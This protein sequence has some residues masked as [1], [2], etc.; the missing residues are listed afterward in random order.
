MKSGGRGFRTVIRYH[1]TSKQAQNSTTFDNFLIPTCYN[2]TDSTSRKIAGM[3]MKK[4]PDYLSYL[5]RLWRVSGD[6]AYRPSLQKA[7]WRVSLE[8][9]HTHKRHGFAGLDELFEFLRNQI[10]ANRD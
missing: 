1:Y 8:D 6:E 5:L 10:G 2:E 9:P 4:Q 7:T 3:L